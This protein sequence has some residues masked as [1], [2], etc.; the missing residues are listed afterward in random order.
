[1]SSA[2][3]AR[4]EPWRLPAPGTSVASGGGGGKTRPFRFGVEVR[5]DADPPLAAGAA[6][7]D[8][9]RVVR[10]L[11]EGGMGRVYEAEHVRIGR[12][13][14]VKLLR[15]DQH[16][17][18]EAVARFEQEA[19][20][21]SRIGDPGIVEMLD[22]STGSDGRVYLV[23][24]LLRGESLEDWLARPGRLASI[25][26][27]LAATARAL[28]A[29]HRAGVIHRDVKPANVFLVHGSDDVLRPKLL[30]FGIA[31]LV[32]DTAGPQ[33]QA[34]TVLGTPYYLAPERA[35][36]KPLDPRADLYSLGVILYEVLAGNVPFLGE[37]MMEILAG[38]I[39]QAPL[40]PRQ[41]APDRNIPGSLAQLALE[42]LAKVPDERPADGETVAARLEQIHARESAALLGVPTGPRSTGPTTVARS[43]DATLEL[44]ASSAVT[45][46]LEAASAHE[47]ASAGL[48]PGSGPSPGGARARSWLPWA[49][50]GAG[51]A[52]GIGVALALS[53]SEPASVPGRIDPTSTS[54]VRAPP[55]VAPPP[56]PPKL[57]PAPEPAAA[58][59]AA[60]PPE[61]PADSRASAATRPASEG[62]ERRG[63]TAAPGRPARRRPKPT[64]AAPEGPRVP[65]LKDDV[66]P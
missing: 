54:P 18:P 49:V 64:P 38:H 21:S 34:G 22:F 42:L 47:G 61:A 36:G 37:T 29:A 8:S 14:A 60:E 66:Y 45:S 2:D 50:V 46:A 28:H 44:Q 43:S 1:V 23:M 5:A 41:A 4:T 25:L 35:M 55:V 27:A 56:A 15:R 7:G 52:G 26:P 33:T 58:T 59:A 10:L 11:G 13:V 62:V 31:K 20:A 24:E 17:A 16:A 57:E 48:S 63:T 53:T 32:G 3:R 30:D 9:Y 51:V 6:L 12:R 40:D 65:D 39:R 19:R